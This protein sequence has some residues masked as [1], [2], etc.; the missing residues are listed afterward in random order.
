V[1][2]LHLV[3]SYRDMSVSML[4][5]YLTSVSNRMLMVVVAMAMLL[6][7]RRKRWL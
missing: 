2:A 1:Q 3:E 5:I 6:Y 4:D 7:F